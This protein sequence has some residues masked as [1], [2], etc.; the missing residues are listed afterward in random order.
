MFNADSPITT[1]K[2]DL[3]GRD[4]FANQLA[5]AILSYNQLNSFNIGLYGEWGSGKT[6]VIN[7][8]EE[9]IHSLTDQ[10][11]D[12]PIVIRFNPW[13]FSDQAQLTIQFFKQLSSAFT[14]SSVIKTVGQTLDALGAAFEFTSFIPMV[15]T[16]SGTIAKLVQGIG[17]GLADTTLSPDIQKLKNEIVMKLEKEKV[18]TI[19]IIDD[20]DR[21]SNQEIRSI[22]QLIK[23]IAD[24]PNTIY[25]LAFDYEIVSGALGE[26]QNTDGRKYLEKI[27]QVPFH[28]PKLNEQQLSNLFFEGLNK[29]WGEIPEDKFDKN[30]WSLLFHNGIKPYLKTIR[31]V[32][33]LNNT[34][35]LKFSFLKNEVSIID[36]IGITTVQVFI[37]SLFN[38]LP[39]YKDSFCGSFSHYSSNDQELTSFK[40][41][42]ES[43]TSDLNEADRQ[44]ALEILS[45]L[46][47]KVC[48]AMRSGVSGYNYH[49]N[50]NVSTRL[51][52][53]YN[54][55]YFNRYFSLSLNDS[56]SLQEAE[57]IIYAAE[58]EKLSGLLMN[59][60]KN[61][62]INHF[63]NYLNSTMIALKK[64]DKHQ[65]RISVL[66][67][68]ILENWT[69]FHDADASQF[70]SF[71]WTWRLLNAADNLLWTFTEE[72]DRF[73]NL[74]TV[75]NNDKIN[76]S[77]KTLILL[78][79]E[80]DYNRFIGEDHK[81][82]QLPEEIIINL[83]HVLQLEEICFAII[84]SLISSRNLI[85][86]N[87]FSTIK[88]FIEASDNH[89]IK[90]KFK[91]YMDMIVRDDDD[92]AILIS[93]LVRHGKAASTFIYEVWTV[94]LNYMS[95]YFIIE[96]A[97][98][99]MTKYIQHDNFKDLDL[100]QKEDILAFLSFYEVKDEPFREE[101]TR[102]LIEKF[103]Q[104]NNIGLY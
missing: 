35:A 33:R 32:V 103:A 54:I 34:I 29:I 20:V 31:D 66:L 24:F 40:Q 25:L 7:M 100:T 60:D 27:I 28:L 16:S 73:S 92:L 69:N 19:I 45:T 94:D 91:E 1:I 57:Y 43:I 26:V 75:L 21:L 58:K 47:P 77:V 86:Q 80:H 38:R 67:H 62:Q 44:I 5:K 4:K 59:L 72:S 9:Y 101:A 71:P 87:D 85:K 63:L 49:Y 48:R 3:L 14:K 74:Q 41:V 68:M 46:F 79:I 36:L 76:L 65:T 83:D 52:N 95:K 102:P 55:D 42:Y 96:D 99:R 18:K 70:F 2:D 51:G 89:V 98:H 17:K 97:V 6:S 15:G 53:I 23:S 84:E 30:Q 88:W 22:F 104:K 10:Q 81:E 8:V 12:K 37:P 56:L 78:N 50:E 13:L 11:I 82:K 61:N 93:S 64:S 39:L 90:D